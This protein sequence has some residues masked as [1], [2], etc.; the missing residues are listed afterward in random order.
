MQAFFLTVDEGPLGQRFALYHPPAGAVRAL[1]VYVHP[2]AEEM[3]KAR[4]MAAMQARRLAA[5]GCAVLQIDLLGCG[6]S[7]GDFGDASWTRWVDDVVY[8][9]RWLREQTPQRD[10]QPP[11]W[12]WGL[13]TGCLLAVEAAT[14]LDRACDFLFWQPAVAGKL[15]LK[16]FMRLKLAGELLA[17]EG[18]AGTAS[19]RRLLADGQ[20]VEVAGYVLQSALCAGLEAAALQP[21]AGRNASGGRVIWLEITPFEPAALSPASESAHARWRAAGWSVRSRAVG[22]PSFWQTVEIE[23]AP[24]LLNAT[25]DALIAEVAA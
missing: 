8:A 15:Q 19:L 11:L 21:P 12:L 14:R 24:A 18:S 10:E 22:G 25:T 3:N 16:Q 17:E 1:V 4:R 23:D 20:R 9:C 2:F 13:R 5:H 7:A 6:D